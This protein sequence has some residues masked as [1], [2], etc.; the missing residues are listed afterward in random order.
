MA[1][2]TAKVKK[3]GLFVLTISLG[4]LLNPLNSS[5]ISVALTRLQYALDL[6]FASATWLIS[7]FYLASAVGQP[8]MGK[9]GDMIGPK[10]LFLTGLILVALSSI[11]APLV[12]SF[13]WL[14]ACRALQAI[15]SSSLFP[16]GMT[17]VRSYIT[18]GQAKA[19]AILSV[20]S[21]VS[22]AFGPSI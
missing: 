20:F 3:T 1:E 19:L 13:P 21:N 11:L 9:L 12:T 14:L 16:S 7:I 6:S 2:S 15:G 18:D 22:A 4:T 8:V 17:M 10:R 5:M